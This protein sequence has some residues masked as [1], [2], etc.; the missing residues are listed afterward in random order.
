MI[1]FPEFGALVRHLR[2]AKTLDLSKFDVKEK[3]SLVGKW[4]LCENARD[5]GE[6]RGACSWTN[7]PCPSCDEPRDN[8]WV[9]D[10]CNLCDT[11]DPCGAGGDW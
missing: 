2:Q 3:E 8:C 11:S 1:N 10:V 9:C 6:V 7:I 5:I 4:L